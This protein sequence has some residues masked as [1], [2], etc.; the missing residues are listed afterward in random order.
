VHLYLD[1]FTARLKAEYAHFRDCTLAFLIKNVFEDDSFAVPFGNS[2]GSL[3]E[4]SKSIPQ[5]CC[6]SAINPYWVCC[7]VDETV[8]LC[9]GNFE[10]LFCCHI[11]HNLFKN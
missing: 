3:V 9:S 6:E 7:I 4:S 5:I 1:I 11:L 2:K 8:K 10:Y